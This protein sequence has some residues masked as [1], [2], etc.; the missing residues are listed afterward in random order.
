MQVWEPLS[1]YIHRAPWWELLGA[2]MF[3]KKIIWK[4][5]QFIIWRDHTYIREIKRRA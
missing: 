5:W 4:H 3:G 1:K 2:R